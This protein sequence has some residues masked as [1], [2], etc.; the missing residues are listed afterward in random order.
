MVTRHQW[1]L[2]TRIYRLNHLRRHRRKRQWL[3]TGPGWKHTMSAGRWSFTSWAR[4]IF[5]SQLSHR[6]APYCKTA[7]HL[8]MKTRLLEAPKEWK[9]ISRAVV[10][11]DSNLLLTFSSSKN[12]LS[13]SDIARWQLT[14]KWITLHLVPPQSWVK[15]IQLIT[16]RPSS[17]K[18]CTHSMRSSSN[19]KRL[20]KAARKMQ[21]SHRATYL[22]IITQ[23]ANRIKICRPRNLLKVKQSRISRIARFRK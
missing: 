13:L 23:Q 16:A 21:I 9:K 4:L 18:P 5:H 14:K 20:C 19:Q 3:L 17:A 11:L 8:V 7:V 1:R 15:A 22:I 10:P 12:K 2:V 6:H